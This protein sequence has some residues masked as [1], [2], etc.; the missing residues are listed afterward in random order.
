MLNMKMKCVL[1][2]SLAV[3]CVEPETLSETT[4]GLMCTDCEPEPDPGDEP[5]SC[6]NGVC[7]VPLPQP[8]PIAVP[9]PAPGSTTLCKNANLVGPCRV[10]TAD[11][12]DLTNDW[13]SDGTNIGNAAAGSLYIAPQ[14][15]ATI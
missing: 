6:P 15:R 8:T 4:Q 1:L 14:A 7:E 10:F 9:N 13:W 12:R 5:Q 2:S 11:D 3:A